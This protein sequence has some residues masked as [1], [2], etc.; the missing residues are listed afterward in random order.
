MSELHY[1]FIIGI[2]RLH[3]GRVTLARPQQPRQD[4]AAFALQPSVCQSTTDVYT[5]LEAQSLGLSHTHGK[6]HLIPG[7]NMRRLRRAV[8]TS[9]RAA[10]ERMRSALLDTSVTVPYEAAR[11]AGQEEQEDF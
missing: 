4:F 9:S 6:G 8:V 5:P 3:I 11:E 2:E 10:V 7:P 1:R